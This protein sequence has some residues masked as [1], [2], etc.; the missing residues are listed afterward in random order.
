MI[1]GFGNGAS[2]VALFSRF[3][4]GIFTKSADVGADLVGKV[5]AGIPEDDPRNPG[6]IADKSATMSVTLPVWARNL[7]ILLR[8]HDRLK[9]HC[10]NAFARGDQRFG[11][12]GDQQKLM[13]LPLALA[14]AGIVCS[15]LGI[16]VVRSASGKSPETALRMGPLAPR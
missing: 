15:L 14:S 10:G 7:R 9:R 1:H 2:S 8:L 12:G 16:Q 5:E 4:G 11:P 6:V 3:G 13:F